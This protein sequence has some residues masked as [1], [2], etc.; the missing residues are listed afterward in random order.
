MLPL[1]FCYSLC[2]CASICK[3][4]S[5]SFNFNTFQFSP[6]IWELIHLYYLLFRLKNSII[7]EYKLSFFLLRK[8]LLLMFVLSSRERSENDIFYSELLFS[9]CETSKLEFLCVVAKKKMREKIFFIATNWKWSQ[10][11]SWVHSTWCRLL[12]QSTC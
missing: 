4:S 8:F 1:C 5:E 3:N 2:I 11:Y 9:S 6:F 7:R 10:I 12:L